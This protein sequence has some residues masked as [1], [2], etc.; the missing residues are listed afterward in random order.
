MII[1]LIISA[2]NQQGEDLITIDVYEVQVRE[3]F[4]RWPT[5]EKSF[6]T[7]EVNIIPFQ[8]MIVIKKI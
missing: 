3:Q 2:D 6:W 7:E 8:V 4:D 1:F 5:S